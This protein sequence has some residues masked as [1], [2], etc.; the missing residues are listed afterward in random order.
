M[1]LKNSDLM[2]N[3]MEI[4]SDKSMYTLRPGYFD[5]YD[6]QSLKVSG[7]PDVVEQI[8][9]R[10]QSERR[11]EYSVALNHLLNEVHAICYGFDDSGVDEKQYDSRKVTEFLMRK[12][13]PHVTCLK[14]RNLFDR[15]N[16]NPVSHADPIA[17]PVSKEEYFDYHHHVGLCLKHIV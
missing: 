8:R 13:V 10:V 5:L 9:L 2:K 1:L 12:K 6:G 11:N 15:R 17:W 7:R 3:V 14:V 16:K 4:Y